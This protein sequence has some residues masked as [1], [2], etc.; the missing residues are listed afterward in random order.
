MLKPVLGVI[1]L[2]RT[3]G[4]LRA[5]DTI[6]VMTDG[7]PGR[8]TEVVN[9]LAYRYGLQYFDVGKATAI[10]WVMLLVALVLTVLYVRFLRVTA[11]AA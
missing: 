1:L 5:F 6:V 4:G 2:I 9:L 11:S 7:G 10:G 3:I 8:A